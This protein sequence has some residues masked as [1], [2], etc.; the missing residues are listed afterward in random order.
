MSTL[1]HRRLQPRVPAPA[2][3]YTE[4][5]DAL[6]SLAGHQPA[7]TSTPPIPRPRPYTVASGQVWGLGRHR[8][9]CGSSTSRSDMAKLFGADRARCSFSSPPYAD[10]RSY[11]TWDGDFNKLVN[12]VY[13]TLS[14]FMTNDGQLLI[15]FGDRIAN[16][17]TI[18]Y[19]N[20]FRAWMVKK[21]NYNYFAKYV[22]VKG[23]KPGCRQRLMCAFEEIFHFNRE[24]ILPHLT[25]PKKPASM[26]PKEAFHG[27]RKTDGIRS[28]KVIRSERANKPH[29]TLRVADTVFNVRREH[30]QGIRG[31]HPATFPIKLV[32]EVVSIWSNKD[33]V[34]FDPFCG[35]GT[36]I[37]AAERI[38]RKMLG[39][40]IEPEYCDIALRAWTDE[41]GIEPQLL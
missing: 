26:L 21:N 9:M 27:R 29:P 36:S 20:D 22:W 34:C 19:Y 3:S 13:S 32:Q 30:Q 2:R 5:L 4:W 35:S 10:M 37:I 40:E 31:E 23:G 33:D 17:T 11:L 14:E 6:A 41:T 28:P 25:V 1:E 8:L 39:M 16:G 18:E 38:N 7:T 12:G 15:N 24:K